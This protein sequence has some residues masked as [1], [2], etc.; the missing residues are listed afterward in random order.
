MELSKQEAKYI[1]DGEK[2]YIGLIL[3]GAVLEW[4]YEV[5]RLLRGW[6]A[7]K[8]RGCSCEYRA[9]A[10]EVHSLINQHKHYIESI[11]NG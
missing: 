1:L 5:E 2:Q 8:P 4:Y 6:D 9:L 10:N 3:K 7:K 11:I